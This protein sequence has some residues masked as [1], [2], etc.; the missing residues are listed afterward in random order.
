ML[1]SYFVIA[2]WALPVLVA[3]SL[4]CLRRIHPAVFCALWF[5][6]VI[7]GTII[8]ANYVWALDAQLLAEVD[9]YEPGTPE[10]KRAS[11][12]WASDTDRSF[13][14]IASPVLSG[15]LYSGVFLLLF[16]LRWV[17]RQFFPVKQAREEVR[18]DSDAAKQRLDDGNP[19][20]SPSNQ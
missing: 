6:T 1:P 13:L 20:Q 10:A 16:G 8:L 4:L 18:T 14:L 3:G 9:K 5:V 15:F 17:K 11:E 7:A 12:E 2:W 19:Y